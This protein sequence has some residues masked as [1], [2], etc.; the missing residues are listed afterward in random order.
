[1]PILSY[2]VLPKAGAMEQ[3]CTDLSA[4]E[5]CEVIPSDNE[6]VVVLVTDTPDENTE[7]RLQKTLKDLPSLQSINMTFGHSG[8]A[9]E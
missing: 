5:C 9:G 2:L 8:E 3:L 6:E 1:M 4:M 7:K